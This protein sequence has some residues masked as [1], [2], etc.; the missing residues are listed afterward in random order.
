[1]YS[2][3]SIAYSFKTPLNWDTSS[4]TDMSAMFD[5]AYM[6]NQDLSNWD[7]SSVK[8][9]TGM[10]V[11]ATAML[12]NYPN[13]P[14][15]EDEDLDPKEWHHYFPRKKPTKSATIQVADLD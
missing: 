6:F 14:R 15:N 3:F 5:S 9:M 10:F 1:M 8:Y 4:V 11:D 13:L 12:A 7:T 2:M